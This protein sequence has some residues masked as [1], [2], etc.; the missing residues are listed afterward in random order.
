MFKIDSDK[1]IEINRGDTGTIRLINKNGNFS[2][3]DKLKISIVEK[4]NY[5]NVIFQKEFIV[6]QEGNEAYITL[7]SKDTRIGEIINKKQEYWYE[8]EYN[9]EQTLVGHD[10]DGAKKFI[11]Y[12]EASIK[13]GGE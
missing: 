10:E 8:I 7:T 3:G 5:Q 6:A 11:L 2:I 1:N 13:E 12:P 4:N 9:G